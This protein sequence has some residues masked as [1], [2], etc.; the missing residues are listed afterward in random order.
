MGVA[1]PF[2]DGH[3]RPSARQPLTELL[4]LWSEGDPRM[5][6]RVVPLLYEELKRIA[7]R[8]LQNERPEHTLQVT[9]LVHEAYLRLRQVH[10]ITWDDRNQFLG[11]ASHLIRRILVEHARKKAALKRGGA[12]Q[13]VTLSEA[14]QLGM[15]R[16]PDLI[17][18]DEAL[19]ALAELD[20]RK[21]AVV[22]LRFFGGLTVEETAAVLGVSA[23]T[24]GREWR[25][26]KAWLYQALSG[27]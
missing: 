3:T 6:D 5:A 22:E 11:F 15:S 21:A 13:R 7:A 8:E 27:Q 14:E 17:V 20:L 2:G 9:A 1:H 19:S 24:V 26:A 12:G 16:P 10:G 25:R 23:E 18:L 4:R